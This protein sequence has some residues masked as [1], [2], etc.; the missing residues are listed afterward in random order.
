MQRLRFFVKQFLR[1][2]WWFKLLIAVSLGV[3]VVFSGSAFDGGYW[4]AIAKAAAAVLF[5]TYAIKFR[6][7]FYVAAAL[8]A[9]TILS[10]YLSWDLFRAAGG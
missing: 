1:E 3:A 10:I 8:T 5:G 6:R 2:P 4:A 9:V 7:S